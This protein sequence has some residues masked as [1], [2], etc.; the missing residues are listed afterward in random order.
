MK[1]YNFLLLPLM[2]LITSVTI[3]CSNT[4]EENTSSKSKKEIINMSF[5]KHPGTIK[6]ITMLDKTEE[7]E[8]ISEIPEINQ[9]VYYDDK[10][11]KVSK[12]DAVK[13]I[14]ILEVRMYS[15][16]GGVLVPKDKASYIWLEM[17]DEN[18]NIIDTQTMWRDG[19]RGGKRKTE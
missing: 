18:G 8:K 7:I 6:F 14:P 5:P 16:A 3:A 9:F 13:A 10:N 2:L 15:K 11:V 4:S 17:Y 1:Y 19:I 12:K